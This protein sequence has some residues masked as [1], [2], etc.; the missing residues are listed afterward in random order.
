MELLKEKA[1]FDF[2]NIPY[3]GS[4]QIMSDLDVGAWS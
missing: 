1:G 3:K 2:T 4:T